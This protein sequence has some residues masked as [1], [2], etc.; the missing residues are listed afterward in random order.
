[1]QTEPR[2]TGTAGPYAFFELKKPYHYY[3]T[4]IGSDTAWSVFADM[5]SLILCDTIVIY[6]RLPLLPPIIKV[7]GALRGGFSRWNPIAPADEKEFGCDKVGEDFVKLSKILGGIILLE[8]DFVYWSD[9]PI[10]QYEELEYFIYNKMKPSFFNPC[11]EKLT[12]PND[13]ILCLLDSLENIRKIAEITWIRDISRP[14]FYDDLFDLNS[15]LILSNP[16][17]F[18]GPQDLQW[19]FRDTFIVLDS[20]IANFLDYRR[21]FKEFR[22]YQEHLRSK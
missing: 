6:N 15:M 19:N 8:A 9:S 13:M 3:L 14:A 16:V 1:M 7:P 2:L 12:R 21:K 11:F 17:P 10:K 5:R 4:N 18:I 20:T 22:R